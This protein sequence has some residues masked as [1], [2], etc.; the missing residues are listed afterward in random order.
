MDVLGTGRHKEDV[1]ADTAASTIQ[2]APRR[3]R[4]TLLRL[5]A[6]PAGLGGGPTR[7]GVIGGLTLVRAS[8]P[9][10]D[11]KRQEKQGQESLT[12]RVHRWSL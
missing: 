1:V 10:P 2:V 12:R 11:R 4:L 5:L 3:A 8:I 7:P 6:A 9:R